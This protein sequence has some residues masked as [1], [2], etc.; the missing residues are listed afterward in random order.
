[1]WRAACFI[2]DMATALLDQEGVRDLVKSQGPCVTILIPP[3]IPGAQRLP[4]PAAVLK[5]LLDEAEQSL[6]ARNVNKRAIDELLDPIRHLPDDPDWKKGCRWSR[7]IFRSSEKLGEFYIHDRI[8]G[9]VYT[10][11]RFDVLPIL[12]ELEMPHEFYVVTLS[13]NRAALLRA[14]FELEPVPLQ[15]PER[16]EDF[17]QLDKPDHDR[18]NRSAAAAGSR[19]VRFGTGS[20]REAF[21]AYLH[22]FYRAIDRAVTDLLTPRR[23]PLLLFGV[24]E[25]TALYRSLSTYSRLLPQSISG[26]PDDGISEHEL[27]DRSVG[28]VKEYCIEAAAKE[29]AESKERL[30]PARFSNDPRSIKQ[31]ASQGRVGHL[32]VAA[33]PNDDKLNELVVETIRH[34][35]VASAL[36]ADRM[37]VPIAAALR[38]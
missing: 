29:L 24:D 26:S 19:R 31:F 10:D 21:R 27:L 28:A 13:K 17:L 4:A 11:E 14:G 20:E 8:D 25:D 3:F 16:L 36:P 30:A 18:E 15:V 34:G 1:M 6:A 35:G 32:F 38:Y 12:P 23:P 5:N 33:R 2:E 9:H 7:A 37:D 22:D